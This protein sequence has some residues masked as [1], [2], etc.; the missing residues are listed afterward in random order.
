[1]YEPRIQD[2]YFPC[3]DNDTNIGF[4]AYARAT[5]DERSSTAATATTVTTTVV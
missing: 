3:A 5:L 2:H 1:M 4:R